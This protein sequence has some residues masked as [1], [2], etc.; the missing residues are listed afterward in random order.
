MARL[1]K[2]ASFSRTVGQHITTNVDPKTPIASPHFYAKT[3]NEVQD[4][5][6]SEAFKRKLH[7]A[8][9]S[10]GCGLLDSS[11]SSQPVPASA[12]AITAGWG[13]SG[14][15]WFFSHLSLFPSHGGSGASLVLDPGFLL[16]R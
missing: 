13:C 8:D 9:S 11:C 16:R 14:A 15:S 4:A 7:W 10:V 5:Y 12:S 3:F 1:T 2:Y 6:I